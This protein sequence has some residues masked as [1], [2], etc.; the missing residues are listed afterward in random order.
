MVITRSKSHRVME[1][2]PNVVEQEDNLNEPL[3]LPSDSQTGD[4]LAMNAA[5]RSVNADSLEQDCQLTLTDADKNP[6]EEGIVPIAGTSK[7]SPTITSPV[8]NMDI[9][10]MLLNKMSEMSENMRESQENIDNKLDKNQAELRQI[11]EAQSSIQEA[12]NSTKIELMQSIENTRTEMTQ[13]IE[14]NRQQL[15]NEVNRIEATMQ[16]EVLQMRETLEIHKVSVKNSIEVLESCFN[17]VKEE[18]QK[19]VNSQVGMR[20]EVSRDIQACRIQITSEM[21]REMNQ[22]REEVGEITEQTQGIRIHVENVEKALDDKLQQV[23]SEIDKQNVSLGRNIM[24]NV[25]DNVNDK[26]NGISNALEELQ[27]RVS[28]GEAQ[29]TVVNPP[30]F[31]SKPNAS[32]RSTDSGCSNESSCHVAALKNVFLHRDI[33]LP[34]YSGVENEIMTIEFLDSLK[35]YFQLTDTPESQRLLIV[36]RTLKHAA[37]RWFRLQR[38][39]IMSYEEFVNAFRMEYLSHERLLN[40]RTTILTGKYDSRA[41]KTFVDYILHIM[42]QNSAL[43]NPLS[44]E[45][46]VKIIPTHLPHFL[47]RILIA[48]R[49]RTIREML[50]VVK[51]VQNSQ[52]PQKDFNVRKPAVVN[53]MNVQRS[54]KRNN[55]REFSQRGRQNGNSASSSSSNNG[56]DNRRASRDSSP[57]QAEGRESQQDFRERPQFNGRREH[58]YTRA[59]NQPW[60]RGR[61][62]NG[63][64]RRGRNFH[65]QHNE[66]NAQ[67]GDRNENRERENI[68]QET[69]NDA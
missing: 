20:E 5:Q 53:H 15:T 69:R 68:S 55:N 16:R 56:N 25:E 11:R 29:T 13:G 24:K 48:A 3:I 12:Q 44:D 47:H 32:V 63:S 22:V 14:N 40:L 10:Q 1:Q 64:Y 30:L 27:S 21:N 54:P 39:N 51:E 50:I 57:Q 61:T 8:I 28:S 2:Q 38:G 6:S 23:Y 67:A 19:V 31:G 60:N 52:P 62:R 9:V 36:E 59:R 49:P 35:G 34:Q 58:P 43:E 42:Q 65:Y 46:L 66:R 41:H 33:S 17:E 7:D 26:I 45:E 18:V 37:N 4:T